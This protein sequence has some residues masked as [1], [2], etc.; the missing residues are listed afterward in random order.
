MSLVLSGTDGI[1]FPDTTGPLDGA[2]FGVSTFTSAQQ[3]ITAGAQFTLAHSLGAEPVSVQIWIVCTSADQN[4]SVGD[5]VL[6]P[7][8]GRYG[9]TIT[10]ID[11]TNVTGTVGNDMGYA[12]VVKDTG[13]AVSLDI[14]T[15]KWAF[16]VKAFI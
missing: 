14:A 4:Y 5:Q 1:T 2:D 12:S 6:S 3:T 11:A 15:P 13:V 10:D 7:A 16:I 8:G 9:I